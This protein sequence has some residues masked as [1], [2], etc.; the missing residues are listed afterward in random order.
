MVMDF[1]LL[2][3]TAK[4]GRLA[5]GFLTVLEQLPETFVVRDETETLR[6]KSFWCTIL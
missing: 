5:D 1:K 6:K 2:N 3:G 4:S